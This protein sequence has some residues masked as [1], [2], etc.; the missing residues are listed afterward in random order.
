MQDWGQE[1]QLSGQRLSAWGRRGSPSSRLPTLFAPCLPLHLTLRHHHQPHHENPPTSPPL[2]LSLCL[3]PSLLLSP[4]VFS[5]WS[6][7]LFKCISN[8]FPPRPLPGAERLREHESR[9][10]SIPSCSCSLSSCPPC[11]SFLIQVI[12]DPQAS[13]TKQRSQRVFLMLKTIQDSTPPG[14]P[15]PTVTPTTTICIRHHWGPMKVFAQSSPRSPRTSP[16]RG[17]T[18]LDLQARKPRFEVGG[19]SFGGR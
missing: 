8:P 17:I 10:L 19:P 7:S 6:I 18:I 3:S 14:A 9:G 15:F 12:N 2:P 13:F 11:L 16:G 4:S 5:T 1:W